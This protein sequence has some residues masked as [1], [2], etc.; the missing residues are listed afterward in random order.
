MQKVRIIALKNRKY[1]IIREL[2]KR[3]VIDIRKSALPAKD[4]SAVEVPAVS[5][6]LVRYRS[7]EV[8]LR[9]HLDKKLRTAV[10]KHLDE[11]KVRAHAASHRQVDG[12][13]L[14]A[15]ARSLRAVGEVFFL[16]DRRNAI[17]VELN[18]ISEA[19]EL[20]K[21]LHGHRDRLLQARER[22][23]LVQGV[24]CREERV[25]EGRRRAREAKGATT[26]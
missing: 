6:L 12:E 21:P 19:R 25:R 13:L 7:A 15:K 16:E 22:G 20:A 3:G 23:A 2:H 14:V 18:A 26:R 17:E 24:L 1:E 10:E 9:K 5:E 11:K 8:V 4:D